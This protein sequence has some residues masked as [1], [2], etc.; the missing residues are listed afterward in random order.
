VDY[1]GQLNL[2]LEHALENVAEPVFT[3]RGSIDIKS[4]RSGF[5]DF[6]QEALTPEEVAK[7]K[8]IYL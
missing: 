5:I 3:S 7:I 4:I 2:E 6:D 8:V 1:D